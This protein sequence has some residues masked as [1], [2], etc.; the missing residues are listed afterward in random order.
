[1]ADFHWVLTGKNRLE[2]QMFARR[3][4]GPGEIQI[5]VICSGL[6]FADAMMLKG[7]YLDAPKY[8]FTP[9]YEVSGVVAAV[10]A[11]VER[12][13]VG[14]EV[15]AGLYFGG[16]SS[17]VTVS[18][19]QCV[20]L[21]S[22]LNGATGASVLVSY[23]TAWL[24]LY[25]YAR[26]REGD[27]VLVDCAS[28]ALGSM[29]ARLAKKRG[30][31][32]VGLTSSAHKK[33]AILEHYDEAYTHEEFAS[34]SIVAPFDII[35]QSRGGPTFHQ[36]I[37]RLRPGGRIV[38]LGVSELVSSGVLARLRALLITLW[39]LRPIYPASLMNGNYGVYGLNVLRLFDHMDVLERALSSLAQDAPEIPIAATFSARE[40]EKAFK[41]VLS[42]QLV[43]KVLLDWRELQDS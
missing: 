29:L 28:G 42:K 9:G 22:N 3:A 19:R 36:L 14:D 11:G 27:R 5:E 39:G 40:L 2:L 37:S 23:L 38:A 13:R 34:L 30:A 16:Y 35:I 31:Y 20:A 1:M 32:L 7:L 12:F 4:P 25:E 26:V 24:S 41:Q 17:V 18:E 33:E 10:G 15:I 8:P 21:P 43:G 6:N